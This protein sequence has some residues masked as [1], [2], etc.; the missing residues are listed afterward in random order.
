VGIE[1]D[2]EEKSVTALTAGTGE[3]A[4]LWMRDQA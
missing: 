2:H 4:E 1:V 3:L